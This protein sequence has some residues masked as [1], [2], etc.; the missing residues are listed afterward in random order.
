MQRRIAVIEKDKCNPQGCGGYLCIRVSPGNRMGN[1]VF[2][3]GSD[4]KA[5][6]NEEVC[7]DA[8]SITVKKCPFGAIHM[9]KL[10]EKLTE[11][12]VHRFGRDGFSLFSLAVPM[13]GQVNGILGINGIGKSTAVKIIAQMLTPNFGIKEAAATATEAKGKKEEEKEPINKLIQMFK[14]SEAQVFFEK[15]R[16]GKIRVSV[17]PQAVDAIPKTFKGTAQQLLKKVCGNDKKI[18]AVA[19]ELG[20]SNVLETDISQVSGGELQRIAI[21]AAVLKDDK[22]ANVFVFDEPTSYLDIRQRI[23]T[24]QYIRKLAKPETAVVAVEHDLIVM[25]YLADSVHIM[26]GEAGAYGIASRPRPARTA[27]NTYLEGYLK[28]EN[29][30]FRQHEIRFVAKPPK[31]VIGKEGLVKWDD[32]GKKLGKFHFTAAAGELPKKHVIGVLGENGLGK[33]TFVKMLAG[34][35]KPDS[36]SIHIGMRPMVHSANGG[37]VSASVRIS[38]KPQYIHATEKA[39]EQVTN[40]LAKAQ[41]DAQLMARLELEPLL[42]KKASELSG[43]ELQRV[44]IAKCLAEDADLYLLDEPAAYLDVEQRIAVSKLL[45]ERMDVHGKTALVVDHDLMLVDYVSD[46]LMVFEGEPAIKG[47][48]KGPFSMEDGM[49]SF[50]R[51][52]NIT[53][54]RDKDSNRPRINSPESRLDRKQ[55]AEG[56]YYYS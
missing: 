47:E 29:M 51:S 18:A 52:L 22:G 20:I 49:N 31:K 6:V 8:E 25:D 26:Y 15:V 12:P 16:D 13:F 43:G 1:E 28:E 11:K 56:K 41:N 19:E 39:D 50:L 37:I 44:M 46:M 53:L 55:K 24:S 40:I 30:R 9:V 4:G 27:I 38:Y 23:R 21:A 54:R 3:I 17:K 10:P 33:T 14:G 34:E 35:I 32:F 2:V 48:A 7:T 42:L 45:R 36:G 5:Q